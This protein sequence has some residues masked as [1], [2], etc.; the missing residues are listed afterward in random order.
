MAPTIDLHAG[1]PLT[2]ERAA[3]VADWAS[4]QLEFDC[5]RAILHARSE[6]GRRL[7]QDFPGANVW[8]EAGPK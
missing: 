4:A 7:E 6:H 2:P 5:R 8:L 3:A 1:R